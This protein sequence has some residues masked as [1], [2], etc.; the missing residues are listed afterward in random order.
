MPAMSFCTA[1]TLFGSILAS[2]LE[3][4]VLGYSTPSSGLSAARQRLEHLLG[5]VRFRR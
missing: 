2:E 1:N 4:I 3:A 5:R